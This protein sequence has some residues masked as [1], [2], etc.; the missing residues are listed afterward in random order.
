MR[1]KLARFLGGHGMPIDPARL[2]ITC[3]ASHG[4]D[5]ILSRYT[6]EGD[7]V[8]V[9][10]P[11]YFHAL[12]ILRA[13]HVRILPVPMDEHGLDV[14]A[15]E[16]LLVRER[17]K[18]LYTIPIHHNPTSATLSPE[19]RS[20]LIE[21]AHR[22]DF[23]IAADEVYQLLTYEG[24][25][26]PPLSSWDRER[27]LSLGS[28][29]KILA[30]GVRLG[31]IEAAPAHLTELAR[32]GVLQSGGGASPFAAAIVESTIET[33]I[34]DEYLERIRDEYRRRSHTM[35]RMLEEILPALSFERPRGG[36]FVWLR[37][38]RDAEA[39][40]PQAHAE[41]VGFLPGPRS[42]IGGGLRD[43][44]RLCFTYYDTAEIESA[45]RRFAKALN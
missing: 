10:E 5:L 45:I 11:T 14:E 22:H 1:E 6:R 18:L 2:F 34:L 36:F 3:G 4:L 30:P 37:L 40:L 8:L 44:A 33:G 38:D 17:P 35:I 27:V 23:L 28:F 29:S 19:R 24:A 31:W 42:S 32:C 39:L 12:K 9:E 15:M 26:P 20:K 41:G 13:R 43:R 21:L 25:P 16:A 7:T